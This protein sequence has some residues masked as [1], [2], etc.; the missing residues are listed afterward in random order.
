MA[1]LFPVLDA[2]CGLTCPW[3]PT[4]CCI[5]NKVWIDFNDL[6]FMHLAGQPI[7][8][9]QL[10]REAG[11]ACCY[12]TH[13]GCLLPRPSRPWAC[14]LYVCG[15]QHRALRKSRRFRD[16]ELKNAIQSI[17]SA[18][19]DMEAALVRAVSQKN[20]DPKVKCRPRKA[21]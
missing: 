19:L 14:T 9:L 12:L 21:G 15:T 1:S 8:P 5:F 20:L 17:K 10:T 16:E 7:P 2:L 3:C 11:E 6:L 4:P 13:R 18:R